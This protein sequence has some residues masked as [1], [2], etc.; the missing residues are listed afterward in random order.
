M[1]ATFHSTSRKTKGTLF[2][3]STP[4][5]MSDDSKWQDAI[6]LLKSEILKRIVPLRKQREE[7]AAMAAAAAAAQKVG[8]SSTN[9][10]LG[11]ITLQVR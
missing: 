10:S 1:T 6:I 11:S 2:E 7:A 3:R 4:I 9:K 5:D 8:E